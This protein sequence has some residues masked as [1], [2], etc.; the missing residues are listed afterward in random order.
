MLLLSGP[1]I[2]ARLTD[3]IALVESTPR[4]LFI[5]NRGEACHH[6]EVGRKGSDSGRCRTTTTGTSTMRQVR[7]I[8]DEPHQHGRMVLVSPYEATPSFAQLRPLA[9][10]RFLGAASAWWFGWNREGSGRIAL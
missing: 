9:R 5:S 2:I 7:L 4:A 1:L 10:A 3:D 6:L 8:P